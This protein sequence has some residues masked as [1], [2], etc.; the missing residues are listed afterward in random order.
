MLSCERMS[1]LAGYEDLFRITFNFV[2]V[3][4]FNDLQ[5]K[6]LS[7][8]VISILLIPLIKGLFSVIVVMKFQKEQIGF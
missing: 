7:N 6:Y 2:K 4:C 3:T 8:N 5:H 1:T